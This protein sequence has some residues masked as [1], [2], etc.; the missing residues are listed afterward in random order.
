M[1]LVSKTNDIAVWTANNPKKGDIYL[2]LFN[3]SDNPTPTEVTADLRAIGITGKCKVID[4]WTSEEIGFA[5]EKFT[6]KLPSHVSG[7]YKLVIAKS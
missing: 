2:A 6:Q 4:L 3:I 7:L 5:S 1:T